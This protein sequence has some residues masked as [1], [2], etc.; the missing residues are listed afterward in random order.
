MSV[1]VR[2]LSYNVRSLRDD[3]HALVRVIRACAP[4]VVCLQEAPR[5]FRWR[6]RAAELARRTGLVTV[7][8]GA[9][10]CG[11][12]ILSGLRATVEHTEETTFPLVHGEHRRG[13]AVAGL[14]FGRE[15]RLSVVSCHLSLRDAERRAQG[16]ALLER[17]AAFD[18]PAVVAGD[19]NE[20][21]TGAT[22]RRLAGALTDARERAPVGG[23]FT[24]PATAPR[25]RIDGVFCSDGV[26]ALS[27]G[28]PT[29]PD[30]DDL[31]AASDHLP[32]LAVLSL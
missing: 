30:P 2:L 14:R 11:T 32:V 22:F 1:K 18:T 24:F 17:V 15:A 13:L 10:S 12:M 19:L 5:F 6:K 3:P 26:T 20:R 8:G 31:A 7:T 16:E 28:V 21:P 25:R 4:D 29:A 9:P 23:E 27:C